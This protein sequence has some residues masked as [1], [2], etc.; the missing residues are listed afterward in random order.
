MPGFFVCALAFSKAA[1]DAHP[2]RGCKDGTSRDLVGEPE[3]WELAG[4]SGRGLPVS[5][6]G[7]LS[8]DGF[9]H[10]R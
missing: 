6:A 2:C 8:E 7:Q 3:R 4:V 9:C 10:R 1:H 5:K